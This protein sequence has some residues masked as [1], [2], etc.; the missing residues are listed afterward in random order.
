MTR[1]FTVSILALVAAA[2]ASGQDD[3]T[4]GVYA[5]VENN[6]RREYDQV[7]RYFLHGRGASAAKTEKDRATMKVVYYNKA[8]MFA[9]CAGE[10][11]GYR[12]PHA[13][14]VPAQSNLALTA[15]VEQKFAELNQFSNALNFAGIFFPDRIEPCS[16]A[17]R[18]RDQEKR[19]PP[20]EFLQMAEP[21]LYDFTRYNSCMITGKID[22]KAVD[23][24]AIS[25]AAP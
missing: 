1:W 22:G 9:V 4:L 21:K 14:R 5:S 20:Y 11:E 23:G 12:S 18:L 19:F 3:M 10:A 15:C 2:P 13:R 16:E 6:I 8:V 25:P 7:L 17:S 24:K